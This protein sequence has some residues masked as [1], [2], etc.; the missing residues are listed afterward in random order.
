MR[1][2][3]IDFETAN[4]EADSA[5]AVGLVVVENGRIIERAYHL[6]RP[7]SRDFAFTWVHGL[8]WNDV[9]EARNFGELWPE[10]RQLLRGTRFLAA[11][12]AP[13]DRGVL[14]ACCNTWQIYDDPPAFQ[15]TVQVAR[16]VWRIHPTKLPNVCQHLGIELKHH[17]AD[18]DAEAC[19][20]IMM[21]AIEAGWS[22]P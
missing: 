12:N 18:S 3:A 19:A 20:R 9:R 13:F 1:Y 15:C 16:R 7:P 2:A 21:A 22:P 5:C 6:I 11:H 17:Q 8:T 4:Y 14:A 10:L